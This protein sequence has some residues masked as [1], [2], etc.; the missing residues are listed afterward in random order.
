MVTSLLIPKGI[1]SHIGMEF[2]PDILAFSLTKKARYPLSLNLQKSRCF[3]ILLRIINV[4]WLMSSINVASHYNFPSVFCPSSHRL[5]KLTIKSDFLLEI[6]RSTACIGGI[7]IKNHEFTMVRQ[8]T[9]SLKQWINI[10][11]RR[12][13]GKRVLSERFCETCTGICDYTCISTP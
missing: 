10:L 11:A 2:S 12:V 3:G 9:S 8:H 5:R 6:F 13:F 7:N 1:L 4:E